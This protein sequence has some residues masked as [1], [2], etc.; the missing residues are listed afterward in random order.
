M[1]QIIQ[2]ISGIIF[3]I[4]TVSGF[5][6][7]EVKNTHLQNGQFLTIGCKVFQHPTSISSFADCTKYGK[8]GNNYGGQRG[9]IANDI[10]V[11]AIVVEVYN[12]NGK[13]KGRRFLQ[14]P[15]GT[16]GRYTQEGFSKDSWVLR[17]EELGPLIKRGDKVKI[18]YF[19][20]LRN[21]AIKVYTDPGLQVQKEGVLSSIFPTVSE[22][23]ICYYTNHWPV[24]IKKSKQYVK[25]E[26]DKFIFC[27]GQVSCIHREKQIVRKAICA[28]PDGNSCPSAQHCIAETPQFTLLTKTVVVSDKVS[29]KVC[30]Y[31]Q[32]N[33]LKLSMFKSACGLKV[34]WGQTSC[35]NP[36]DTLVNRDVFCNANAIGQC[37]SPDQCNKNMQI[38][39]IIKMNDDDME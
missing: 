35:V 8:D 25:N 20:F 18:E 36:D 1:K 27:A 21:Q 31:Q 24:L 4:Y 11:A 15:P 3:A 23:E 37:P 5:S 39:T 19:A 10:S 9:F 17:H 2:L 13:K 22:N 28:S 30:S 26:C 6:V 29:D 32:G 16:L 12:K 14:D 7:P 33:S 34:C 38:Y